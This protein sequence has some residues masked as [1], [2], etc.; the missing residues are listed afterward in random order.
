M[1]MIHQ[2]SIQPVIL[3]G[4]SGSRLWPL[5]RRER[6]KQFLSIIGS[7]TLLHQTVIRFQDYLPPIIICNQQHQQIIAEQ[8]DGQDDNYSY[9][10]EPHARGTAI[11]LAAVAAHFAGQN[12]LLLFVPSDHV[13]K[14]TNAFD[15]AVQKAAAAAEQG[16]IVTFGATPD[17]PETGFG[18]ILKGEPQAG[19]P[20]CYKVE[21]FLEKPNQVAAAYY[22]Q[23]GNY[24]WNCGIFL[25][26]A[27]VILAEM[28]RWRPDIAKA[29]VA[30][31]EH[32]VQKQNCLLLDDAA[33][34]NAQ[35]ESF[36]KAVMEFTDCAAIVPVDMG[37]SDVGSWDAVWQAT[38]K[39]NGGNVA[40]GTAG[41]RFADSR[42]C[43]AHSDA[44]K[45]VTLG[46]EDL[47]VI[48]TADTI[49]IMPR[50]RAQDV[51]Q[52]AE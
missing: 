13:I 2:K 47:V 48:V 33:M 37:W 52:V 39:D 34:A 4:G 30:A 45:I 18:Y 36:D 24:L 20:G 25:A 42:N 15:R 27:D 50:D 22:V 46:V 31:V 49:M 9:I 26:R 12:Q 32:A 11:A 5:S 40:T 43:Y 23:E 29:A 10:I 19:A 7:E 38:Q 1:T 35:S 3:S 41:V 16:A 17:N 8:L 51:R 44:Q 28:Q 6:P 21:K 14:N